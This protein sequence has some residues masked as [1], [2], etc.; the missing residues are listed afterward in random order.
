VFD[1]DKQ[2]ERFLLMSD[3]FA[4]TNIDGEY[5]DDE[6]EGADACNDDNPFQNQIAGRDI[7]QLKNNMI[8]KGLV[9]RK[10]V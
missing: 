1:D 7:I 3:K 8:L 4:N 9:A 10:V 6:D 5:Y 2:V